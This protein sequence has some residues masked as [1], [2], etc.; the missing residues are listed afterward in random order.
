MRL[1]RKITD[2]P[3]ERIDRL[4]SRWIEVEITV[5]NSDLSLSVCLPRDMIGHVIDVLMVT[6]HPRGQISL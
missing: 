5:G 3:N 6:R 1:R 2:V 4:R